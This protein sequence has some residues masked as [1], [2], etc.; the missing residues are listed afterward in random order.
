MADTDH[1]E[2]AAAR[3][4]ASQIK[5][6]TYPAGAP[7]THPTGTLWS[8]VATWHSLD[9]A[10]IGKMASQLTYYREHGR[11]AMGGPRV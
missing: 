1:V 3:T 8:E 11:D 9:P 6:G 4:R 2:R 7:L 10:S 5:N